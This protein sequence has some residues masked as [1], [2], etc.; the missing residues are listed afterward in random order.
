M[1]KS[2]QPSVCESGAPNADNSGESAEHNET[3]CR[4]RIERLNAVLESPDSV[5]DLYVRSN[6]RMDGLHVAL[7]LQFHLT[8]KLHLIPILF[9]QNCSIRANF[10]TATPRSCQQK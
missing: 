10:L 2:I 7:N 9:G 1:E 5:E 4:E 8:L 6:S 3:E